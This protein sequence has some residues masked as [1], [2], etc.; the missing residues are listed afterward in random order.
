ML[1]D[2]IQDI[3]HYPIPPKK[4]IDNLYNNLQDFNGK[5]FDLSEYLINEHRSSNPA[6][7]KALLL[8]PQ[9]L[10]IWLGKMLGNLEWFVQIMHS[11]K[12]LFP[13]IDPKRTW[14]CMYLARSGGPNVKTV[15]YQPKDKNKTV[16]DFPLAAPISYCEIEPVAEYVLEEGRWHKIRVDVIHSVENME[17]TRVALFHVDPPSS[18][19]QNLW[20]YRSGDAGDTEYDPTA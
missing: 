8:R 1:D 18:Q 20:N 14:S 5:E 4:L 9:L 7:F 13:H 10:D 16:Q 6:H 3:S 17:S 11:G 12:N 19:A 2:Y 15:Y